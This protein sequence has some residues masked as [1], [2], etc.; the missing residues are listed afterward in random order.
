LA[1]VDGGRD[2]QCC[3]EVLPHRLRRTEARV[4]RHLVDGQIRGSEQMPRPL[5]ALL[6][7]PLAGADAGLLTEAA[8]ERPYPHGGLLR[9]LAQLD[10]WGFSYANPIAEA[11]AI[12]NGELC[13]DALAVRRGCDVRDAIVKTVRAEPALDPGR[14]EGAR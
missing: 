9:P 1:P 2:S 3:L 12:V 13:A 8:G 4:P 10:L 5:H 14:R 11:A 7:Q 6:S